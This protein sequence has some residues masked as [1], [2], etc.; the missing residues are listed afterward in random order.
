MSSRRD[1]AQARLA[2]AD[3]QW[4]KQCIDFSSKPDTSPLKDKGILITGGASGLGAA[5]AQAFARAGAYVVVLD[6]NDQAGAALAAE[7]ETN[8]LQ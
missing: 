4:R 1:L 2:E 8:G 3:E 6:L 5:F 7:S